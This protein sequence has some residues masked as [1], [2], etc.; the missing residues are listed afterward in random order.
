MTY[1]YCASWLRDSVTV[2][3]RDSPVTLRDC[4]SPWLWL[5]LAVTL[6]FLCVW[7][8]FWPGH[9]Q[10]IKC[11]RSTGLCYSLCWSIFHYYIFSVFWSSMV[12][13]LFDTSCYWILFLLWVLYQIHI[14]LKWDSFHLF[15]LE[16]NSINIIYWLAN[17]QW[18]GE[19]M[20]D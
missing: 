15:A 14:Q 13:L 11:L 12:C 17:I 3:L 19:I 9:T 2:T 10:N 20:S 8:C 4:D 7:D 18:M 16:I 1:L 5:S 6:G